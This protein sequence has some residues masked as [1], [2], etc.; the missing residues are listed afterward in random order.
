[1]KTETTFNVL[2]ETPDQVV[3]TIG[4]MTRQQFERYAV[5]IAKK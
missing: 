2:N 1:M 5:K 4:T 3:T